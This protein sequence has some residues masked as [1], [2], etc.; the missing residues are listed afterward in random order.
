MSSPANCY[1]KTKFDFWSKTKILTWFNLSEF[2]RFQG[3]NAG[4]SEFLDLVVNLCHAHPDKKIEKD[5]ISSRPIGPNDGARLCLVIFHIVH[6]V[7]QT[8]AA[9]FGADGSYVFEYVFLHCINLSRQCHKGSS[10]LLFLQEK[11]S[12]FFSPQCW[13]EG[14]F[15]TPGRTDILISNWLIQSMHQNTQK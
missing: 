13:L 14:I 7:V 10:A 8:F 3:K 4:T 5:L 2:T 1:K 9:H 6:S 15:H 11:S 12:D